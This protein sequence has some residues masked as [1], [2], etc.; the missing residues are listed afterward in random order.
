MVYEEVVPLLFAVETL[1]YKDN[2]GYLLSDGTIS[3]MFGKD[4][5]EMCRSYLNG[6]FSYLQ[7]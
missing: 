4:R 3:V 1:Q 6:K 5:P 7:K 2:L